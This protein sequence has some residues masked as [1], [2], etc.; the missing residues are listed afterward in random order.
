VEID[1]RKD[2]LSIPGIEVTSKEGSHLLVYFY[3]TGSLKKFYARSIKPFMGQGVMSSLSLGMEEIIRRARAYTTVI[4]FAHPSCAAYTGVFNPLFSEERIEKLCGAV[5]GVEVINAGNLSKWNLQCALL[6]FN[7]NKAITGGSDGHTLYELGRAISYAECPPTREA[8]L[9][10][11]REKRNRVLGKE[12]AMLR[13]F[14]SN[15]YKLKTNLKNY[16]DLVEKNLKYSYRVIN[17]KSKTLRD[18]VRQR[19]NGKLKKSLGGHY[20]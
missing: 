20:R 7:L 2:I 4:V 6:G 17:L 19:L 15:G 3:S 9:D 13:K 5:D 16:P 18:N 1:R 14:T 11:V 10:A 8:F 12:I